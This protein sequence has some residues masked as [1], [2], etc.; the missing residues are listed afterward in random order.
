[1][2]LGHTAAT[3]NIAVGH[4]VGHIVGHTAVVGCTAVVVVVVV[5]AVGILLAAC[6]PLALALV[7][8]VGTVVVVVVGVALCGEFVV[9]HCIESSVNM[10]ARNKIHMQSQIRFWI[11]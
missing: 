7:L 5:V 2:E 9:P 3:A 11:G 4:I 10:H 1:M 6:P 8:V